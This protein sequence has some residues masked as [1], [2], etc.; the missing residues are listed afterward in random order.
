MFLGTV[1]GKTDALL[2][3]ERGGEH[4]MNLHPIQWSSGDLALLLVA[5]VTETGLG[6]GS[7]TRQFHIQTLQSNRSPLGI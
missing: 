7:Y 5:R 6:S 4:M 3:G 2:G 1:R